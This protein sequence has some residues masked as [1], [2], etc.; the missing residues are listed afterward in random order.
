VEKIVTFLIS[1]GVDPKQIVIGAAFYGRA[2]KGVPPVNHGLYQLS[3]GLHIGWS[4]YHHIRKTFE[5]DTNYVRFWDEKAKAPF[6]YNERDS[7][8]ISYDDTV[9][10]ALKTRYAMDRQ[11]G[12]IMFW[13]LGNDTK[14][15][16]SLLDA[17]YE[18]A[19]K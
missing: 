15:R 12:G 9:S 4:A 19:Q 7:I 18:A 17:I 10:V 14:E 6:M 2:W 13:E 16:G 5:P 3:R 1:E 11:L 8:M